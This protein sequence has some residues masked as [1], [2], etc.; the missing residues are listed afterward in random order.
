MDK[1]E[2]DYE[3]CSSL[4]IKLINTYYNSLNAKCTDNQTR[5]NAD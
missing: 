5:N 2:I 3:L 4:I 1:A